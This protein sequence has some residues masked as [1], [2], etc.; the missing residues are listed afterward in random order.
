M[1]Q[2]NSYRGGQTSALWK[3]TMEKER[4]VGSQE[5]SLEINQP[6]KREEGGRLGALSHVDVRGDD[7]S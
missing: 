3:R 1:R 7:S 6:K 5:V 2:K 4:P